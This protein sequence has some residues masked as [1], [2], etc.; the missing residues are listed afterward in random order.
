[1]EEE[2]RRMTTGAEYDFRIVDLGVHAKSQSCSGKLLAAIIFCRAGSE[3]L[4][5]RL[6]L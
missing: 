6:P 5:S 3:L 4:M 1:M 2:L